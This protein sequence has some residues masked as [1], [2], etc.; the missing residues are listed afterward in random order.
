MGH[1]QSYYK[2]RTYLRFTEAFANLVDANRAERT[3]DR[4]AEL[5]FPEFHPET[6]A[7]MA[8]YLKER[9]AELP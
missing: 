4:I 9:I 1:S 5:M 6:V 2:G 7:V 3:A 8:R